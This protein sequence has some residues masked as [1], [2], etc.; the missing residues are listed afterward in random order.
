MNSY[1]LEYYTF[2]R[3]SL[4]KL[5]KITPPPLVNDAFRQLDF[6]DRYVWK[7]QKPCRTV[8]IERHYIDRDFIDDYSAFYSKSLH[9]Y[10]NWCQ[11]I[12]FFSLGKEAVRNRIKNLTSR[13]AKSKDTQR[14][15]KFQRECE[16]FSREAYLGYCV[17]K[18][19]S[20]SPVGRTVLRHY[21]EKAENGF[22]R[23]FNCTRTYKVH[24]NVIELSVC[25]LIFQQQDQGVSACATTA[26]W[27]SLNKTKEFE[28][29]GSS[30]PAK[31]TKL[32]STYLLRH[33][34]PMPS[35]GLSVEQMCQAIQAVGLSPDLI[36]AKRPQ[37]K[38]EPVK[39]YL[40][41][42]VTSGYAPI[43]LLEDGTRGHAVTVA[44]IKVRDS[45]NNAG[46]L[47]NEMG[48]EYEADR[49][50]SLYIHDDRYGPYFRANIEEKNGKLILN[51][52]LEDDEGN[53]LKT[54]ENK[55]KIEI[56]RVT[57]LLIPVHNKIR[58]SF[59]NLAGIALKIVKLI[60]AFTAGILED[61]ITN[62]EIQL[63]T[64]ILQAPVYIQNLFF[65]K[66]P[67][68]ENAR[69][70]FTKQIILS[71]YVG[72]IRFSSSKLGLIDILYDTT[73][74]AKN[75]HCSGIVARIQNT[76]EANW[77]VYYL[78]KTLNSPIAIDYIS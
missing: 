4:V 8:I 10:P 66:N 65:G 3:K 74:T 49:L 22:L 42:A 44:G 56:W 78:R 24:L 2:S 6:I 23:K 58:L 71:R 26:L 60:D 17:I 57:H 14:D 70:Q 62:Y 40:Y 45:A 67:F 11:R 21:E 12:H 63:S 31:I 61:Q 37:N 64:K 33:G 73:S 43:L 20:G 1:R 41:S 59:V 38:L 72:L 54:R 19:L 28:E 15:I 29:I 30:T 46:K 13:R 68:S 76:D 55:D 36:S 51:I 35:S 69:A 18:P 25:G 7:S 27:S 5:L 32:A 9:P 16:D 34:R 52:P 47:L 53:I 77:I 50:H 75:P 48:I 39:S